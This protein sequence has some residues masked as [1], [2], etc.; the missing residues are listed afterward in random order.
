MGQ[1]FCPQLIYNHIQ[2]DPG[3]YFPEKQSAAICNTADMPAIYAVCYQKLSES[4]NV[5]LLVFLMV[6]NKMQFIESVN[7]MLCYKFRRNFSA[8][9]ITSSL[10]ASL[11]NAYSKW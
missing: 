4:V 8:S 5:K 10:N 2:V 1:G 9:A 11:P 6:D 3:Q 7:I